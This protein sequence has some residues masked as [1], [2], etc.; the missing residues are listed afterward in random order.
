MLIALIKRLLGFESAPIAT[1]QD[2]NQNLLE[3]ASLPMNEEKF[4]R[5]ISATTKMKR[6]PEQQCELLTE[7]LESL[8]PTEIASFELR[9]EELKS[10]I[11]NWDV[12]GA[13]YVVHGGASDDAFEYFMRW[14]VS[15]GRADFERVLKNADDLGSIIPKNQT[16]PCEYEEFAYVASRVWKSKTGIDPWEDELDRFPYTGAPPAGEVSGVAF[17]DS[18]EALSKRYPKLWS[19]FGDSPL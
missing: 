11:Y 3:P 2:G 7:Q 1:Q 13:T 9:F 8:T 5:I 14:L 18:E 17:E 16:D 6:D 4:W 15:R 12:W 19:R 10:R